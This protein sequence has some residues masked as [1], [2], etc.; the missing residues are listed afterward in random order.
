MNCTRPYSLNSIAGMQG[1][2]Y[3]LGFGISD[4]EHVKILDFGF[5]ILDLARSV[6]RETQDVRRE[7]SKVK[8][9]ISNS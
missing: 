9:E 6:R 3:N 1:C 7:T 4:L 2:F 5:M 8:R